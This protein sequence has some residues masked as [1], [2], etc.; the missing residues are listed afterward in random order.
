M[1]EKIF[2][3]P[4]HKEQFTRNQSE[5]AFV[6]E[7]PNF[8]RI[9]NLPLFNSENAPEIVIDAIDHVLSE[10]PIDQIDL[11]N[12]TVEKVIKNYFELESTK[13]TSTEISRDL[14]YKSTS[15]VTTIIGG[16]LHWC[17]VH[18]GSNFQV[19]HSDDVMS[20]AE[21]LDTRLTIFERTKCGV[22]VFEE[23]FDQ[24]QALVSSSIRKLL[25]LGLSYES[26]TAQLNKRLRCVSKYGCN[27]IPY[28]TVEHEYQLLHGTTWRDG[29]RRTYD[30]WEQAAYY[31]EAI[32]QEILPNSRAETLE[33]I[34]EM[35]NQGV[36]GKDIAQELKVSPSK[37]SKLLRGVRSELELSLFLDKVRE[38]YIDSY[39]ST[40]RSVDKVDN[41]NW[42]D[43]TW[44][45]KARVNQQ[46]LEIYTE[47][48]SDCAVNQKRNP[49]ERNKILTPFEQQI[50]SLRACGKEYKKI[51]LD[52]LPIGI[53]DNLNTLEGVVKSATEAIIFPGLRKPDTLEQKRQRY[54]AMHD[55]FQLMID[56]RDAR[57]LLMSNIYT[58]P[59]R[60]QQYLELL[61]KLAHGTNLQDLKEIAPESPYTSIQRIKAMI[62][63]N[64]VYAGGETSFYMETD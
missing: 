36:F 38:I 57:L 26:I 34:L 49:N 12:C 22:S 2:I 27:P 15:S 24:S 3:N 41:C 50:L 23:K 54:Q 47:Y 11:G 58:E 46:L 19:S 39:N 61:K 20:S 59:E 32:Q 16:I 43:L 1:K 35:T 4:Q 5:A 51:A 33:Q 31:L 44:H 53:D 60:L 25:V 14:G 13:Q 37:I 18:C 42:N 64:A 63:G 45:E 17:N 10:V 52:V 8:F 7:H 56:S 62:A 21:T 6:H 28:S 48:R 9:K 55:E 30:S 29:Q 40:R